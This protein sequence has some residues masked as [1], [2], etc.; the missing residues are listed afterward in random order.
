MNVLGTI[1]ASIGLLLM[2][3]S[4]V[5]AVDAL[6]EF[7]K[8]QTDS[9]LRNDIGGIC[10]F[11]EAVQN[12]NEIKKIKTADIVPIMREK[13]VPESWLTWFKRT[14]GD[15]ERISY[16][17]LASAVF[18]PYEVFETTHKKQ[19]QEM[20]YA[21]KA[22]I[23]YSA[24]FDAHGEARVVL[25][26]FQ[27][28]SD[29][30]ICSDNELLHFLDCGFIASSPFFLNKVAAY[31]TAHPNTLVQLRGRVL[32]EGTLLQVLNFGLVLKHLGSDD[33]A[34]E[35]FERAKNR[36]SLRA[37]IEIGN[38]F[39]K[40][41]F[42]DGLSF[43]QSIG[44]Y[45]HWKIAQCFRYGIK[46]ERDLAAAN[47]FYLEAANNGDASR[48]P[49]ILYDAADFAIDYAYSQPSPDIFKAVI[50][51]AVNRFLTAG[52]LHLGLG[53]I[54]AA[55]ISQE[56]AILFPDLE[57]SKLFS[58]NF[59]KDIAKS[60]LM[61]GHA[62]RAKGLL[63]KLNLDDDAGMVVIRSYADQIDRFLESK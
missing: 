30:D 43:F 6:L 50:K 4:E 53:Y 1:V 33:G 34:L 47:Q 40:R 55:E 2:E 58:H 18:Y 12:S 24:I 22:S 38:I 14:Y 10:G 28:N 60:A 21:F 35:C 39:L 13:G 26:W 29:S 63:E 27:K 62:A 37:S 25:S 54:K 49:E 48:Y 56:A 44:A 46:I 8:T 20:N 42:S 52:N 19:F 23:M 41:S 32:S 51:G 61:E 31:E 45:G 15:Q 16:K 11:A 3:A 7:K 5:F 17:K 59:R 36:G 57:V 9:I